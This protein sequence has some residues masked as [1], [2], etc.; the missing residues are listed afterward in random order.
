MWIHRIDNRQQ[1][2]ALTICVYA[3]YQAA[4]DIFRIYIS[5]L[6]MIVTIYYL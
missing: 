6:F 3:V 1:V 5:P 2:L 4:C